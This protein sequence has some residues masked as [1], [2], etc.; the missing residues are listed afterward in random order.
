MEKLI[1]SCCC[2]AIVPTITQPFLTCEYCDTSIPNPYYDKSAAAQAAKPS[3]ETVCIAELLEMGEAQN[4]KKL[5]P[6]CFGNPLHGIDPSRAGLSISDADQVYF[7]YAHTILLLG[8]SDGLALADSG[9]YYNAGGESG[10][11]SWDAFIN[12]AISCVDRTED[13][14]GTLKIGSVI[15]I[16]VKSEK[17]SRL[18][19][20]LVD[21]HNHVY[22]KHTGETI[23]ATWTVT[24]AA[25]NAQ[26]EEKNGSLLGSLLPGLGALLGTTATRRQTIAQRVPTMHP[27]S[28]PTVQTD[29]HNHV[30]PPRSLHSQPHHRIAPPAPMGRPGMGGPGGMRGPGEPGRS[31]RPGGMG[32]RRGPGGHGRR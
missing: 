31:S 25:A 13:T 3:L 12:G 5:D 14:N 7:L 26:G 18:A 21:F 27:T 8:F 2:A 15:E 28:R 19:R 22:Q 29:R 30:Q 6:Y 9:L 23:P 32:G 10:R 17:D 16:E 4:L 24:E 1:C 11:I 20:F